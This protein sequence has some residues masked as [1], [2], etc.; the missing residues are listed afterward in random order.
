MC[1]VIYAWREMFMRFKVFLLLQKAFFGSGKRSLTCTY[2]SSIPFSRILD[3]EIGNNNQKLYGGAQFHRS[4]REF[5]VAVR[6]MAAQV[7]TEDEI[8]NANGK[9][10]VMMCPFCIHPFASHGS[11]IILYCFVY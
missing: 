10:F 5:T 9:G 8:A 2:S 1:N 11:L 3:E 6:H 7:V 4:L